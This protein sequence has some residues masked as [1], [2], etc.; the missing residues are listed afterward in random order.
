MVAQRGAEHGDR[1]KR[2]EER[3]A[4]WGALGSSMTARVT[5]TPVPAAVLSR[6]RTM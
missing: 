5:S 4:T 1:K 6:P 2:T 3:G